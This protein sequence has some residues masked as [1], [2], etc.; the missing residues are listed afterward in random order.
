M[1][2]QARLRTPAGARAP[3][4]TWCLLI[5]GAAALLTVGENWAARA[6]TSRF[7]SPFG[8]DMMGANDCSSPD[9]PCKTI[10]NAISQSMSGDLIELAPGTYVETSSSP[11]T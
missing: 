4:L 6:F 9:T 7:V 5:M 3:R 10:N 11:R 8:D 1:R 2:T